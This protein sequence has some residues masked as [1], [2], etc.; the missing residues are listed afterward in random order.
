LK[1]IKVNEMGHG[2]ARRG[3][4]RKK[5]GVSRRSRAAADEIVASGR[6][7][8]AYMIAIM[9]DP[10][11]DPGRRD[12]MARAAAPFVHPKL[13]SITSSSTNL[14][15]QADVN[16]NVQIFAVP[17]GARVERDGTAFTIDGEATELKPIEPFK[18]TP[19]LL[20]DQ[21]ESKRR[22]EFEREPEPEPERLEVHEVDI[23]NVTLLGRGVTSDDDVIHSR[24]CRWHDGGHI[25][26]LQARREPG[27]RQDRA[28][29]AYDDEGQLCIRA[30]V[31]HSYAKTCAA[32]SVSLKILKYELR[33]VDD[34]KNF[35]ALVY[36]GELQEVSLTDA[37]ADPCALVLQ[38]SRPVPAVKT[39]DTL[40]ARLANVQKLV[41]A[42]PPQ[43]LVAS[44]TP[45]REPASPRRELTPA[46][47][48]RLAKIHE[49]AAARLHAPASR[50]SFSTMAAEL[51]R[52]SM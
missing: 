52:R 8:L 10:T 4:G 9:E 34:P 16:P 27:C 31:S 39:F 25:S 33:D 30:T 44:S 26:P 12:E 18:G 7:P 41:G 22:A 23:G 3:A 29:L 40:L 38:R 14:N 37:P 17:R 21:R 36:Q 19:P 49:Q 42:L 13:S 47:R 45:K 28:W 6:T 46:E 35:H 43:L 24:W 2:G 20:A 1:R 5:G 48:V 15:Y 51:N 32:F 11:A 50:S